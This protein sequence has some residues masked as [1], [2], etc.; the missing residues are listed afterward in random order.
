[1]LC[2]WDIQPTCSTNH[3][4]VC[5]EGVGSEWPWEVLDPDLCSCGAFWVLAALC[6]NGVSDNYVSSVSLPLSMV[7]SLSPTNPQWCSLADWPSAVV[8]TIDTSESQPCLPPK[9]WAGLTLYPSPSQ[10]QYGPTKSQLSYIL[11]MHPLKHLWEILG[12]INPTPAT[13]ATQENQTPVPPQQIL[14]LYQVYSDVAPT[15]QD[16]IAF[17]RSS[18]QN[19]KYKPKQTSASL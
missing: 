12:P 2:L 10:A 7:W 14:V 13:A 18:L 16:S 8:G 3:P 5:E 15:S 9:P 19:A 1:M 11:N 6:G 17:E 4:W